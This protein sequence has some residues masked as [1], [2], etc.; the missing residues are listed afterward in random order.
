MNLIKGVSWQDIRKLYGECVDTPFLLVRKTFVQAL[1]KKMKQSS[2][3]CEG[4]NKSPFSIV[5]SAPAW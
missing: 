5:V 3:V 2:S 1:L 4:R